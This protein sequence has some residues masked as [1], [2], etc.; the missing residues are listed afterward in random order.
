HARLAFLCSSRY[1]HSRLLIILSINALPWARA[2]LTRGTIKNMFNTQATPRKTLVALAL[3]GIASVDAPSAG[4]QS[5][6]PNQPIKLIVPYPPGGDTDVIGR[7]VGKALSDELKVQVVVDNRSGASGSIG[8]SE[9]ARSKP[10]GNTLLLGALTSH[11]IYQ[12]LYAKNV[13]Y[14]L[15]TDFQPVS[16]VGSV[17][18]VFVVHPSVKAN[19]LSELIELAKQQP[20]HYS[21]ASAGIGSPQHMAAEMFSMTGGVKLTSVP[22]RG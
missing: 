1:S 5:T 22:Y 21:I 17:P 18:L 7:L 2:N 4:A 12:N 11:S 19:S 3:I 14:N 9:V 13:S 15:N 16:I 8:A 10:D 6:Y 20:D